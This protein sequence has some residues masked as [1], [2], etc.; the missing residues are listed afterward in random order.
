M[1]GMLRGKVLDA[2]RIG[3]LL[4]DVNGVGYDVTVAEA[5]RY[6]P[7]AEETFYIHTAV[8]PDAIVLY[9]FETVEERSMFE[10]LLETPGVGP[11]TALAALRAMPATELENAIK[12]GDQKAIATIPGI[13]PKTASRVILELRGKIPEGSAGKAELTTR[14]SVSAAMS[15]LGFAKR[16]IA[17]TLEDLDLPDD[18]GEALKLALARVSR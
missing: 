16:E 7:G 14:D 3:H 6:V 2:H 12:N 18:E 9:G 13:G 8:R 11:S 5:N 17:Q 1:I 4:V 10:L 15:A